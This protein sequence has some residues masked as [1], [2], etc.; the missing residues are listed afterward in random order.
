MQPYLSE[1]VNVE[2]WALWLI[3]HIMWYLWCHV[4]CDVMWCHDTMW[5]VM[6]DVIWCHVMWCVMCD[7]VWCHVVPCDTMWCH[8]VP[9]DTMWC[10]VIHVMS[11][12]VVIPCDVMCH[13]MSCGTM[14][15]HVMSCDTCDEI[16]PEERGHDITIVVTISVLWWH[17][18]GKN[19]R[20]KLQGL[21][22]GLSH[23]GCVEFSTKLKLSGLVIMSHLAG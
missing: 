15:C 11:C 3:L 8:V 6:C 4:M 20:W 7:T 9:C 12:D 13:V 21:L 14:W 23:D 17:S 1:V 22:Y 5:C 18:K 2:P 19:H 10:H 16:V